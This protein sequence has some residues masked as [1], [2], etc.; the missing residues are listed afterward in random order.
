MHAYALVD[1]ET[2]HVHTHPLSPYTHTPFNTPTTQ[3]NTHSGVRPEQFLR[4]PDLR[5]VVSDVHRH[6]F[7]LCDL[8]SP[9]FLEVRKE[10]DR[11]D[12]WTMHVLVYIG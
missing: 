1:G 11:L 8:V 3:N 10:A 6:L 4:E 12:T 2:H 7:E 9:T 5:L